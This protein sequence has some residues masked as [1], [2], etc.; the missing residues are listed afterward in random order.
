[1]P[2]QTDTDT[3]EYL[4]DYVLYL[5]KSK[6]RAG[7]ERQR[8]ECLAYAKRVR[9]RIVAT[10]TEVDT[11]AYSKPGEER[12][13]RD[14]YQKMLAM[15]RADTRT[16]PLGVMA[17][18]ADRLHRN[19][20]EVEDF[21]G[22]AAVGGH[23]VET[24]RSGVYDLSTPTGRKRLRQ[25]A[26][27]AQF[28]VDHLTDRLDSSKTEAAAEG[29][30]LGGRRPFGF[31]ADGVT[32]RA[33]EAEAI[34]WGCD[35]VLAGVSMAAIAREWNK[36]GLT[37]P[38]LTKTGGRPWDATEAR[39]VLLRPRNA[40][41]MVHRGEI[42]ETTLPGGH[43]AWDPIVPEHTWRAV[44]HTLTDP[45]RRTS[46]G[47]TPRWLGSG[48]YLC[49]VCGA[50]VR[51]ASRAGANRRNRT[52]YT[53]R[54]SKHLVRDAP[55]VDEFVSAIVVERLS[56]PDAAD[57]LLDDAR[58]DMEALRAK[59]LTEQGELENWRRL[60]EA[61]EV[62]ALSFARTEKAALARIAKLKAEMSHVDRAPILRDLVEAEDVQAAWDALPLDRR[63]AVVRLLLKVT[64][65]K[66]RRGRIPGWRPG[67]PYFDSST[68]NPERLL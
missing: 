1:M 18:H 59:L 51:V 41:L 42:I 5:R 60:A 30:W 53:C 11:T 3:T 66:G 29:R 43:A 20:G 37:T 65:N 26:V 36:R 25:D 22:V 48:I 19:G 47:P 9:G 2:P 32:H 56:R 6:G 45:D 61:G 4:R 46:P 21:I 67:E 63:R 55:F 52:V 64:V 54:K 28:E 23:L 31:E 38:R 34:V 13:V 24:P 14:E 57:L 7:I 15:L 58:P 33:Q 27:D 50:T 17:W 68:I 12:A 10:F 49:G 62:T 16:P 35:A 8:K 40:G 44:V 39:R